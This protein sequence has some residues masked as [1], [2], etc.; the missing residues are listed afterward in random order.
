MN[1]NTNYALVHKNVNTVNSVNFS[2]DNLN[3]IMYKL[4]SHNILFTTNICSIKKHFDE[5]CIVIDNIETKFEVIVLTS[6]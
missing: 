4:N 6:T 3:T 2:F 5:I 1:D